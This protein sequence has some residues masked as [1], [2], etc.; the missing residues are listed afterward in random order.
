MKISK[1]GPGLV[2]LAL[3]YSSTASGVVIYDNAPDQVSGT[4]MSEQLV[5]ENFTLATAANVI[6]IRFWA[7]LAAGSAY[8]GNLYWAI[9]SNV[10]NHPGVIVSGG[11]APVVVGTATGFSTAF[12]YPE[13]SFDIPVDIQLPAGA[14]WLALHNG[15]LSNN[16]PSEMLWSTSASNIGSNAL[17]LDATA[18][19]VSSGNELAFQLADSIIFLDGFESA[20]T[21]AWSLTVP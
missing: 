4:N 11:A 1:V 7:I 8:R 20:N 21:T 17:Y 19:W 12:G 13:Y 15:D 3:C 10:A 16:G 5:A 18:G 6:N 9:Y 2:A 14:Y